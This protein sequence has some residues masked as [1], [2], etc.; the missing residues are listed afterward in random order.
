M[1]RGSATKERKTVVEKL[2][3]ERQRRRTLASI[4]H[5]LNLRKTT[6]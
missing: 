3:I 4:P 2:Q 5:E 1:A 6:G